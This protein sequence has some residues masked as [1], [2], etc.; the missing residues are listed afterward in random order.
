MDMVSYFEGKN[1]SVEQKTFH[2]SSARLLLNLGCVL[3]CYL[4][5]FRSSRILRQITGWLGPHVLEQRDNPTFKGRMSKKIGFFFWQPTKVVPSS[6]PETLLPVT[7]L[8][9][10]ETRKT[11]LHLCE[12]LSTRIRLFSVPCKSNLKVI[13]LDRLSRNSLAQH[14]LWMQCHILH[15][16]CGVGFVSPQQVASLRTDNEHIPCGW[17]VLL[18]WC[19]LSTRG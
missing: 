12:D 16:F 10:P 8:N 6:P 19:P 7:G 3:M 5:S 13:C 15:Y 17:M 2:S 4:S 11:A 14:S 9:I 1:I 18:M